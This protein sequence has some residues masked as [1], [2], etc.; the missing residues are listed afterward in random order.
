MS[1]M[2]QLRGVYDHNENQV[3]IFEEQR[4]QR[5]TLL[6]VA[7]MT[8][9]AQIEVNLSM[10]GEFI[11]AKV[12]DNERTI[13]PMTLDSAN[14]AGSAVR[15][16]YLHD[17][18]FYVAGDY[19]TY[20]GEE[21]RA[22]YFPAYK[23]QLR[24]WTLHQDVPE[25]VSAI[26]TYIA[27]ERLIEDLINDEILPIN[28]DG[29][30]IAK[31]TGP[32]R[33]EIYKVV[34]GDV[35]GAFV[36]FN[37]L[38]S[39]ATP[40]WENK[41]IFDAFIS[42]FHETTEAERGIC[43]VTGE[44]NTVLTTQHGSKIRNAGDLSKLI[45]A[46]DHVGFTYRGRFKSPTEA[47]QVSFDVSQKAHHAL[48]WLIQ[49]QGTYVDGR[50]FI[51]FGIEQADIPDPF[52]DGLSFLRTFV[53]EE[54]EEKVLTE[55]VVAR[56]INKAMQ[57][58]RIKFEEVD[59]KNIVVMAVDAATSGRLAIVYYQE[60]QPELYLNAI[61]YW[62]TTCKWLMVTRNK[63]TKK[64][65]RLVG[66]PSTYRIVEAVYG[67]RADAR[68]KKE[69]YTRLL[70]CIIEKK[71]VPK[72]IIRLIFNRVVNP[73]S[74]QGL[75]E[76][77]ETTLH[78]ACA[79][80]NKQYE[81][82]GFTLALQEDCDLRDY[83]FGRLLGVAEVM[84]RKML[85]KSNESRATNATRYFNAFSQHPARTWKVIRKQLSP[86][87]VRTGV[88]SSRY[89]RLIQEI[90]AKMTIEQMTDESLGPV[91]LLGYSS[92]IQDMYTKKEEKDNDSITE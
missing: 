54:A 62:H 86:Y 66:T 55:E 53:Q 18:L 49:R 4:N 12:I 75:R 59:L 47:V 48:R 45:S 51:S 25:E 90:E 35:L 16:H 68:I 14:R 72:D 60:M 78:I 63:E 42:Y 79:L 57:G 81:S 36:R 24:L 23:E 69:L 41:N 22:K 74:F 15:P 17:K 37:I 56:E 77:W 65:R 3:G 76:S 20:G 19:L 39:K 34:S 44:K 32:D 82:E 10:Q 71:P 80:I 88:K 13:V 21:K 91:F 28:Q 6:P 67:S 11:N 64:I 31:V 92:Q 33:P 43:Y 83:L 26:Y 70:P 50:Y 87:F 7:H 46:N 84:E 89:T 8:Q 5:I 40:V 30:V 52:D 27:Q 73:F 38:R 29:K 58:Y 2:Q 85:E 9:S 61:Q 1:W